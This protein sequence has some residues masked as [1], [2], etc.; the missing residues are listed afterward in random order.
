M[1]DPPFKV[2][3]VSGRRERTTLL[4][5]A[6][7]VVLG[8]TN[9]VGVRFSNRE[10]DPFW[11]A[12]LRFA[13]A[14]LTLFFIVFAKRLPL[15]RR[16]DILGVVIYGVLSFTAA[17]AFFYWGVVRV[18]AG[19]A[20]V[21]MGSAPLITILLAAAQRL[22]RLRWHGILGA[23]LALAGIGVMFVEPPGGPIPLISL[24]AVAS[25]A[26]C[27]AESGIVI[28]LLPVPHP[29]TTNAVAMAAGTVLLFGLSATAGES[30]NLPT[31]GSTWTALAYLGVVGSPGLFI[32]FVFVL[33][34]WTA[35]A[36]SYQ[37]VLIPLVALVLGAVLLGEQVTIS[38]AIGAP[39][40][41]AGVYVGALARGV[42]RGPE[43]TERTTTGVSSGTP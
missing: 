23:L 6:F 37:F 25:A 24:L 14:S 31:R 28:K 22:E 20:G 3:Y 13:A 34:R 35:S 27:A 42:R 2:V 4:A 18:P 17:Y 29:V 40:V 7:V 32:L 30:W 36:A 11:G 15:P 21:I 10:L 9:I 1:V 33:Q 12:G 41:V 43:E 19:L 39:L 26:T 16:R 5:F 38:V 8:G